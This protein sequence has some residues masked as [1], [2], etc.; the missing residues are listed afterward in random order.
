[1]IQLSSPY[2]NVSFENDCPLFRNMS[3]Y[4]QQRL[5]QSSRLKVL[6]KQQYL[7]MQHSP[8]DRVFNISSGAGTVEKIS[9]S[10]RRQILA[11]IFPGDFVGLS[12]SDNYEYGVKSLSGMTAYEFKRNN[13]FTLSEELPTLEANLKEIRSLVL[14]LTLNQIYLLGQLKAYERVCFML[15][16]LLQRIPGARPD[17]IELPMTRVDIADYLGLTVETVSR[18]LSQ[19]KRDGLIS[20]L[21]PNAIRILKLDAVEKLADIE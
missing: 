15:K 14:A 10:G 20:T 21:S 11:F 4:E 7:F 3:E 13:L 16:E 18:S 6:S 19:L 8:S 12:Q 9:S 17:R 1:M 2:K 5:S